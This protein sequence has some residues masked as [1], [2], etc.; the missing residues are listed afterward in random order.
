M[1]PLNGALSFAPSFRNSQPWPFSSLR[2]VAVVSVST[3]VFLP[4]AHAIQVQSD[5]SALVRYSGGQI[6]R[7]RHCDHS[8]TGAEL[9]LI[10]PSV[11]LPNCLQKCH[12]GRTLS[13][14]TQYTT[15]CAR[16]LWLL[17]S[18]QTALEC[19]V[20]DFDT[21]VDFAFV[22]SSALPKSTHKH[23]PHF[24]F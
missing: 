19:S 17:H 10:S 15:Y 13:N 9:D 21:R 3:I 8:T 14:S 23:M 7:L 5:V 16:Q 11:L 20:S 4:V 18:Y 22:S 2:L 12:F 1:R 24:L 6:I